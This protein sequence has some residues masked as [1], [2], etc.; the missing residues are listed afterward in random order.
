MSVGVE[1]ARIQ[2]EKGEKDH[3]PDA[4]VPVHKGVISHDVEEMG[5][6]HLME[7]FV[8]EPPFKGREGCSQGRLQEAEVPLMPGRPPYR[9]IWSAWSAITSSSVRKTTFTNPRV[10]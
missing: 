5:R 6:G 7:V 1:P 9:S 10:A 2:T 4:F 8:Q 3:Q